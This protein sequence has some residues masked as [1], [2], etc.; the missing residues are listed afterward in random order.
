MKLLASLIATSAMAFSLLVAVPTTASAAPYPGTVTTA[1]HYA[2][3]RAVHRKQNFRVAYRITVD[4][5][6]SPRGWVYLRVYRIVHNRYHYIRQTISGNNGQSLR[7]VSLGRFY[8]KGRYA[9][10]VRFYPTGKNSVYT[11]C[12][13]GPR[14]FR[15]VR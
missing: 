7:R 5:N 4:G 6:G 14:A 9:T 3:A 13:N 15:V 12:T 1:C 11:Q 8:R 2:Q 10:L